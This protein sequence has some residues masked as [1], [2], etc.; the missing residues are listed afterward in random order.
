MYAECYR[1]YGVS[2]FSIDLWILI[3][4]HL[5]TDRRKPNYLG[6]APYMKPFCLR[7]SNHYQQSLAYN[8]R[9]TIYCII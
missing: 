5:H 4:N 2:Y 6:H 1:P 8:L 3:V 7:I 9:D